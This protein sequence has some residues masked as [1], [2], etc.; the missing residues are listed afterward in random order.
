MPTSGAADRERL[1][2]A[3]PKHCS[4]AAKRK[5][6]VACGEDVLLLQIN[7]QTGGVMRKLIVLTT[8]TALVTLTVAATIKSLAPVAPTTPPGQAAGISPEEIQH[9]TDVNG[10]PVTVVDQ[11]Y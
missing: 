2:S 3:L 1:R 6:A 4:G 8:A 7:W 9:Q 11:P 5:P 10:L